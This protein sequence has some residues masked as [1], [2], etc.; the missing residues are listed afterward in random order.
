MNKY[1]GA[2]KLCVCFRLY[3]AMSLWLE[4][5]RLHL[6]SLYLPDLPPQYLHVRLDA[7][8]KPEPVWLLLGL[9][10]LSVDDEFI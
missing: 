5:P 6:A 9:K 4:E 10:S 1:K 8:M 7:L 2:L 3:Y